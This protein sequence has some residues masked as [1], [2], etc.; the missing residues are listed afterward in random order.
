MKIHLSVVDQA[1]VKAKA[2]T[3]TGLDRPIGLQE[4]EVPKFQNN[5]HMKVAIFSA[6]PTGCLNPRGII[7]GTH[8][9]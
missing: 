6:L 4:F 2:N 8:L 1:K 9:C 7:P 3:I 5:R